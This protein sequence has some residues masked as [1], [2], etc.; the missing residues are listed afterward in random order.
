MRLSGLFV[1]PVK[2]MRAVA[3][4]HAAVEPCGLEADRRWMV[5]D[6]QGCFLSQRQLP[7][8]ARFAAHVEADG[9]CLRLDAQRL[10]VTRPDARC[11]RIM[12]SLWR[13]HV[14]VSC[15]GA[16][17]DAWLSEQLGQA[18]RLVYLDDP[19]ARPIEAPYGER[20]E[21]VSFA[22]GF[23]ALLTTEASLARLND[24]LAA[25]IGMDRFRPNLVV[26]GAAAWAENRWRQLKIG[27][28]AFRAPKPCTRCVITT[29]D[30]SSGGIARTGEP[31]KTLARLNRR[32]EGVVFGLN[33]TPLSA[34][35]LRIGDPV[36]ILE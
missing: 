21:H 13:S 12:V 32:P 24:A 16:T 6:A 9:L 25:P 34:G 10:R 31:L 33:L 7:R 18:C 30:Q 23:P 1:Y 27:E 5:V 15:A 11:E 28:V 4:P 14:L 2:S 17:A 29:I 35:V 26:G 19:H 20:G 36:T 3:V 22:D 8:L